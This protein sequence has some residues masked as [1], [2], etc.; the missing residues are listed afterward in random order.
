MDAT[1]TAAEKQWMRRALALAARGRG[2]VEP[3]PMVGCVIVRSGRVLGEGYHHH[4]GG[5]HAE[6]E[7][8]RHC[9]RSPRGAVVY[10]TLEPCCH[11]GKTGPCTDALLSAGVSRIVAAMTDPFPCVRGRGFRALRAAG[12]R[13]DVGLCRDDAEALNAPFLTLRRTGRP[14][15]I[16]KWAQSLDG[17]L[18]TRTGDSR[19][20]S[21][22]LSRR[23]AHRL[24]GRVDAILVGIGTVVAD[25]PMLTCRDAGRLRIA[26]RI[27]LDSRLRIPLRC[28]L[29]SSAGDTPVLVAAT[30]EAVR[31]SRKKVR[32]LVAAGVEVLPLP[33]LEGRVSVA[34]LLREL[35]RRECTNVLVEGGPELLGTF[36]DEGLADEAYVFVAPRIIGGRRAPGA[37]GGSGPAWIRNSLVISR[38]SFRRVGEDWL[39]RFRWPGPGRVGD[40]GGVP[41]HPRPD[42]GTS[43]NVGISV[44]GRTRS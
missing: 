38:P 16:L 36:A 14:W 11:V 12:V 35:G 4:F 37:I 19:W 26:R 30:R 32:D 8:L 25:D 33:S 29:V 1:F 21:G 15:V 28:Q 42:A 27:V 18:A 41:N 3:N 2:R 39:I 31:A 7:A 10:V 43:A 6:I 9:A 40:P 34:G 23:L 44:S 17:R 13:V 24:R 5:P 20:I 22:D